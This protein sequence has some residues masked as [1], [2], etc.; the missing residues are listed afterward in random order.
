VELSLAGVAAGWAAISNYIAAVGV[1]MLG[2]YLLRSVRVK[3]GW[4]WFG[5]GLLGPLVLVLFY[6]WSCFGMPLT[7]NYRDQAAFQKFEGAFLGVFRLPQWDVL[8]AIL[9]S[10]FRGMF[11]FY[12]VLAMG[13]LGGVRLWRQGRWRAELAVCAGIVLA[14]LLFNICYV[15]WFGGAA[16]APRYFTPA[17]AFLALPLAVAFAH[18][19]KTTKALAVYSV[20]VSLLIVAVNPFST[21]G[22]HLMTLREGIP[23]WRH[24]QLTDYLLPLFFTGGIEPLIS[25][26]IERRVA[27]NDRLLVEAGYSEEVRRASADLKREQLRRDIE[28]MENYWYALLIGEHISANQTGIYEM[29]PCRLFNKDSEA[30]RWNSFNVGEFLFP[31]SRWSLLPFALICA[32]L[33]ASAFWSARRAVTSNSEQSQSS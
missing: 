12:P 21:L 5:L 19:R 9:F 17:V 3:R 10:P 18:W 33:I 26:R 28:T 22:V 1:V 24:N 8:L 27:D 2:I 4:L 23:L 25:E 30:P 15:G 11:F 6:N 31:Q 14:Y 13:V 29:L 32:T 20:A 16:V 7:T